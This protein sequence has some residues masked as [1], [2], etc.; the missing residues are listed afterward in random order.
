MS[1]SKRALLKNYKGA[2]PV[3][4]KK[5]VIQVDSPPFYLDRPV[6]GRPSL[7]TLMFS[8]E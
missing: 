5:G 6:G 1:I 3:G 4:G 7:V 8:I 2:E